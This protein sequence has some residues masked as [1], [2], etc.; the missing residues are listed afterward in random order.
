L[1]RLPRISDRSPRIRFG[2][3]W[4]VSNAAA[5]GRAVRRARYAAVHLLPAGTDRSL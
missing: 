2:V 4:R 3:P 1:K 5:Y